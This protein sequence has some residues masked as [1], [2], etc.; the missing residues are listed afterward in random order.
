MN[1]PSTRDAAAPEL[2]PSIHPRKRAGHIWRRVLFTMAFLFTALSGIWF[3]GVRPSLQQQ[4]VLQI[5][6]TLNGAESEMLQI[7]S[8]DV[9]QS[10]QHLLISEKSLSHA[11]T[12]HNAYESQDEQVTVTPANITTTLSFPGCG[13]NCILTVILN[14]DNSIVDYTQLQVTHAHAQGM[15]ALVLS[16][17]E[18]AN[19]LQSNLQIF[20]RS[21]TFLR[22]KITLLEHAIDVHLH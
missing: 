21:L 19:A 14:V 12:F 16:D 18:L 20:N 11:L 9:Y 4:A 3:L 10:P 2:P 22:M 15:L 7:L 13:Q 8:A 1:T 6:R 17:D 5:D